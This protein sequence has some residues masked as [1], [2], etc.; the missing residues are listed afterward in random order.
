[1]QLC[2]DVIKT[3]TLMAS[4]LADDM[5][6]LAWEIIKVDYQLEAS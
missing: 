5:H 3:D 4:A 6:D 1:M 2:L